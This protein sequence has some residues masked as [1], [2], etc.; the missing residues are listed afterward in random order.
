M[1]VVKCEICGKEFEFTKRPRG[2]NP[3][4]CS[5]KC[6]K[7]GLRLY[8]MQWRH[9]KKENDKAYYAKRTEAQAL[10]RKR[11]YATLKETAILTI[12]KDVA[13]AETAEQIREIIEERCRVR[14]DYI[15]SF[16]NGAV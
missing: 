6:R 16:R 7:E 15:K 14:Q 13:E 11:R 9:D 3:R 12:V 5:T 8:R 10:V 1:P 4:Y 2:R